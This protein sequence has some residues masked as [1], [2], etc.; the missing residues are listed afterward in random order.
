VLVGLSAADDTWGLTALVV[1]LFRGMHYLVLINEKLNRPGLLGERGIVLACL[2]VLATAF[3]V[4]DKTYAQVI[5]THTLSPQDKLIQD[6]AKI[7][8]VEEKLK[9]QQVRIA[10]QWPG[11]T[12]LA[13]KCYVLPLPPPA[14]NNEAFI[15]QIHGID[16]IV[17]DH[18]DRANKDLVREIAKAGGALETVAIKSAG[19]ILQ[20]RKMLA[21]GKAG[22]G[23]KPNSKSGAPQPR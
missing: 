8:K 10:S 21:P 5:R 9:G 18:K 14:P 2:F 3:M 12:M 20:V 23:G 15:K 11:R 19:V 16:Y 1:I 17:F 7:A 22:N 4:G 6:T 13:C